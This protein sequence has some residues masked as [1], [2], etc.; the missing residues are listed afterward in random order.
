[1]LYPQRSFYIYPGINGSVIS[2]TV[3]YMYLT[4]GN[5]CG[6]NIINATSC[7]GGV[8]SVEFNISSRTSLC[9]ISTDITVTVFATTNLGEGPGTIPIKEGKYECCKQLESYIN[10]HCEG[11]G[12]TSYRCP[13]SAVT[14]FDFTYLLT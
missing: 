8:C 12:Y 2:Y 6:S 3:N 10:F 4:S 11:G 7:I 5:I 14:R 13:V 1:M 9:V